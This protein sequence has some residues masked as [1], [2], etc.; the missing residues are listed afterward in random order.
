MDQILIQQRY[1]KLM[2]L[3]I[4]IH[5]VPVRFLIYYFHNRIHIKL[6]SQ[7]YN[8]CIEVLKRKAEL[9]LSFFI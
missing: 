9:L 7:L 5:L 6:L 2:I 8:P 3:Q 1:L 4:T